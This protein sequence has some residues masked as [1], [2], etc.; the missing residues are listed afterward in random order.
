MPSLKFTKG[1]D[2]RIGTLANLSLKSLMHRSKC[3]SPAALKT[4]SPESITSISTNASARFNKRK[5]SKSSGISCTFSGS[6]A[7]LT[8]AL[9][10]NIMDPNNGHSKDEERVEDFKTTLSKPPMARRF[11]L[12]TSSTGN[13]P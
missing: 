10:C 7:T 11:P 3:T 2:T 12:G 1:L 9:A 6:T 4:C 5:P 8:I 13:I